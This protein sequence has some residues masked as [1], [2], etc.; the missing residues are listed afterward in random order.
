MLATLK[1]P[2]LS[3]RVCAEAATGL[4][5]AS[6]GFI[7]VAPFTIST[8]IILFVVQLWALLLCG[9]L[10]FGRLEKEFVY[11]STRLNAIAVG[12]VSVAAA[13]LWWVGVTW[14]GIL[15]GYDWRLITLF[16]II[17]L[18]MLAALAQFIWASA[19]YRLTADKPHRSMADLPTVSVC[20]PA[21][22]EDHAL[23]D[24]LLAVLASDYPKLEVIVLDDCSQDKT[25]Q[26][27][28]SFAHDGV[29][30]IQGESPATGWLGKNQ[31]LQ[32]LAQQ[33]TGDF[34]L[35][36][37]VDTRLS[38]T[39]IAELIDYTLDNNM[40]MISV[41]PHNRLGLQPGALLGTLRDVWQMVLPVSRR[42]VPVASQA[43]LINADK[44]RALGGF[45]SVA[46]KII[47]EISFARR[48][49]TGD[50]YR[51]IAG[52]GALGISTAKRWPSQLSTAA[53]LLYPTYKRQ[54]VFALAAMA[55]IAA[56]FLLPPAV[57]AWLLVVGDLGLLCMLAGGATLLGFATYAL[58]LA[59]THP[60]V[61]SLAAFLLPVVALQEICLIAV[62]LAQ[63]EFGEVNWKGRNVCYPVISSTQSRPGSQVSPYRR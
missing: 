54:P 15:G 8:K 1:R 41:L 4:F 27:V 34:V 6:F 35:F 24:C 22:N 53:R 38:V 16:I 21:R 23:E 40:H 46:H 39:S 59:R 36:M 45:K 28:R 10:L 11:P 56:L 63:Y 26:I 52:D 33:A 30:F 29:Q 20:I 9:R 25:S 55:A 62:S 42:H 32:T 57:L 7:W 61:W 5:V 43:W 14:P 19:H 13:I 2:V 58:V 49:F 12:V 37:D 60:R 31:A 17:L 50:T 47:P 3:P 44:L 51:F 48:L 18:A